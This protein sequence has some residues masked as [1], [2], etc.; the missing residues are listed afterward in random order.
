[1]VHSEKRRGS[2]DFLLFSVRA[3]VTSNMGFRA[4]F[5]ITAPPVPYV[6]MDS[7]QKTGAGLT[8]MRRMAFRANRSCGVMGWG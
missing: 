1:M 4:L 5:A 8:N 3:R 7:S 6:L 2:G